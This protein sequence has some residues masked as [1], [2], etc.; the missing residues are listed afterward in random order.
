MGRKKKLNCWEFKKCNRDTQDLLSLH[1]GKCP[2]TLEERL[3]GVHGGKNAGRSCWV[4]SGTL[5][6]NKVQGRAGVKQRSCNLC[7]FYQLVKKQ[8]GKDFI[9]P[10]E[11]LKI[12]ED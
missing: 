1:V 5:C 3:D 7:D 10:K 11:I 2:V 8:E 4:V 12:L 9:L 6:N